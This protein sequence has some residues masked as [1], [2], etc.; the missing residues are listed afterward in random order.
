[1][2][3]EIP[4][5]VFDNPVLNS[6]VLLL[7]EIALILL[8]L[9]VI[10][11]IVTGILILLSI[12]RKKMY[13]P[14]I[15]RP[16]LSI[17]QGAV[18]VICSILGIDAVEL[19]TFMI[20]IDNQMNLHS[21]EKTPVT[22]RAVFFP[23]C[24]RSAECPAHLTTEGIICRNCGRCRLGEVIPVLEDAG[25]KVFICPGSTLIK[26]MVKK[27]PPKAMIGV[28]GLTDLKDVLE[29]GRRISMTTIGVVTLK[30]GCVETDLDYDKL[31]ETASL[32]LSG[33]LSLKK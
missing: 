10:F 5:A 29:L 4:V 20:T 11:I 7:G 13:F 2:L 18:R 26:R 9:W 24:L 15:L 21:F 16:V 28:G 1:M 19:M 27:Y 30:D 8:I 3:V 6:I 22:N 25:Y 14:R 17:M 32:G 23:Q 12:R 33:H 31:L